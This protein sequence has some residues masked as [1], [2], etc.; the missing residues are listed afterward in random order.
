[1]RSRREALALAILLA[2]TACNPRPVLRGRTVDAQIAPPRLTASAAVSAAQPFV[3]PARGPERERAVLC[4]SQA[5]YYEA[6]LEP[7]AGQ[8][9]VAQTVINR[10][11]HP[12]FPKSVC[13]VVYQGAS[14]SGCQYSFAC[15]G[16]RDRP[17]IEPY[18]GRAHAVAEAALNGY[19]DKAVGAAT[20][21]HADYVTPGWRPDMVRIAQ[22]GA[23]IFYRYAGP[24]GDARLLD[25]RYVGGERQVSTTGWTPKTPAAAPTPTTVLDAPSAE[26]FAFGRRIPTKDDIAAI[27]A[28]LAQLAP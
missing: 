6:A 3:L 9:A 25:A 13:G 22:V 12:D 8:Q 16:S 24:A 7:L 19:V 27:N 18:W 2:L 1:M 23:H 10:L 20:H 11:R 15:D 4:L 17:P 28:K 21:Y 5:V 26:H 14:E